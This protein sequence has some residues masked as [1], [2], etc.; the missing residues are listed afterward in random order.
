MP[1][2]A[3]LFDFDGVI[4][5][6]ENVHVAA[7]Q[8]T[9]SRMGWELSDEAALRA[10]EI[11]DR[12]FL[13]ELFAARKIERPDL[14]G[15]LGR[16]QELTESML[17]DAPQVY[18]GVSSLVEAL[19]SKGV[20]LGIVTTTWRRNVEIV[21]QV[22]NLAGAF[23][24]IIA[25]EDVEAVKPAPEGYRLALDRLK[26]STAEAVAIED[27]PT[28]VEAARAAGLRVVAVGHRRPDGEWSGGHYLRDL[29][30]LATTLEILGL[31]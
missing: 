18:P 21:L 7:W 20:R 9:L 27:S 8:R 19:R 17:A 28:G 16:K 1:P 3:V 4:V 26:I 22:S 30:D 23:E 14:D 5:D 13:T 11:D 12:V 15:W 29:A 10:A 2:R 31:S 6:T 24:V 25:K